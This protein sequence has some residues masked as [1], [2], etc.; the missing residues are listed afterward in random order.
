[1][2]AADKTDY[3]RQEWL[4]LM[5]HYHDKSKT[6]LRR[7]NKAVYAWLYRNDKEWLQLNSPEPR[8][9]YKNTRVDWGQKV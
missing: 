5:N 2:T 4:K 6:E 8:Y 9:T 1:M 7:L 3:Y